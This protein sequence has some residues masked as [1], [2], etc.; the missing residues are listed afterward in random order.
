MNENEYIELCIS[1]A[2]Y[3][4]TGY[5]FYCS[6]K[7]NCIYCLSNNLILIFNQKIFSCPHQQLVQMKVSRMLQKNIDIIDDNENYYFDDNENLIRF[8]KAP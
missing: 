2:L 4:N 3:K 6:T 7:K 8:N 5:N 1:K